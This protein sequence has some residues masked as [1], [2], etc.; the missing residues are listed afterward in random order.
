MYAEF[1]SS[2][3]SKSKC[4]RLLILKVSVMHE[5]YLHLK[6]WG[7][8]MKVGGIAPLP[9]SISATEGRGGKGTASSETRLLGQI[10]QILH[11]DFSIQ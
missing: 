1:P 8:I 10:L 3:T 5:L 9:P 6:K 4:K 11:E 2:N 7:L